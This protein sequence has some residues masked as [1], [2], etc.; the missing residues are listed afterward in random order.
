[1][2]LA[3]LFAC[4]A[5]AQEDGAAPVYAAV[6]CM[7]STGP[8]YVQVEKQ[9]WQPMHQYLVGQGKRESWALYRVMYGDRS[10]CDYYTVTT[11]RGESQLDE[12]ADFGAAFSAVHGSKSADSM[13]TKT[14]AAREHVATELWLLVDRT[15]IRPH[16]YAIVNKMYAADPI[17]YE[18]ME[19]DVFKGGHQAL[20]DSGHRAGWAVYALVSPLGSSIPYNYGTVDL[21]N[22]LSPVPMAEAMMAANPDRDLDAM[23]DLL[24]LR[25]HVL[26]E[27]WELVLTTAAP[28]KE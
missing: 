28:V 11:Y 14:L 26:S 17:A 25:D 12:G 8:D 6:D 9:V 4:T 19:S 20:I 1:M 21:V 16:R 22:G 24:A 3:A 18:K 13:M 27:T 7:K 15:E 10:R 5:A 23:H 2:T